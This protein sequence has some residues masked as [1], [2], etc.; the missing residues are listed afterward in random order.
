[1]THLTDGVPV[2]MVNVVG[3]DGRHQNAYS[4]F[5]S[6]EAVACIEEVQRL[7]LQFVPMDS[8]TVLSFY[9]AQ[10][11]E[12]KKLAKESVPGLEIATVAAF[13]GREQDYIILSLCRSNMEMQIGIVS[14]P[15]WMS[16]ALTRAKRGLIVVSDQETIRSCDTWREVL[17]DY[18][19]ISKPVS[20]EEG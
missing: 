11:E 3:R 16:V 12:I 18:N 1:M 14:D 8:I 15:Q 19:E 20:I 10:N 2:R 13:Q 9:R 4:A 5:N 7:L 17:T 6:T